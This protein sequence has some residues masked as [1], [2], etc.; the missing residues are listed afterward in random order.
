MHSLPSRRRLPQPNFFRSKCYRLSPLPFPRPPPSVPAPA[1]PFPGL[2]PTA[3]LPINTSP[4]VSA[5]THTL[6]HTPTPAA[7]CWQAQRPPSARNQTHP[8]TPGTVQQADA[9]LNDSAV[10]RQGCGTF[11]Q[12]A[13]RDSVI[14]PGCSRP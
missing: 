13:N 3:H 9:Q 7:V 10:S 8:L 5:N 1:S 6:T 11:S 12:S 4:L 14:T 2:L